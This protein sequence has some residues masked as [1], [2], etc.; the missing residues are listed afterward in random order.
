MEAD[1]EMNIAHEWASVTKAMRQRL[2]RLHTNGQR[3]QDDPGE[4]FF[5]WQGLLD[6]NEKLQGTETDNPEAS[7]IKFLYNKPTLK[8]Q[9]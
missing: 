3:D 4:A 9:D 7:L 6:R 8:D 1:S 2:W 5:A